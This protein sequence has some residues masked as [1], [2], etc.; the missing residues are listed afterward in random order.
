MILTPSRKF[1]HAHTVLSRD[2]HRRFFK[3]LPMRVPS[4][5]EVAAT[6]ARRRG[7]TY[8]VARAATGSDAIYV[9]ACDHPDA[10]NAAINVMVEFTSAG[11]RIRHPGTRIAARH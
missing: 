6:E 9:F 8:V 10:R 11:K 7:K 3:G 2:R 5:R 1:A 4:D